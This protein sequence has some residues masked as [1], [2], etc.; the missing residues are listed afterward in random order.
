MQEK[1]AYMQRENNLNQEKEQKTNLLNLRSW[2]FELEKLS[3]RITLVVL[4][5][6]TNEQR[7]RKLKEKAKNF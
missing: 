1:E 7:V 5:I 6:Q 4:G 2:L 3:A